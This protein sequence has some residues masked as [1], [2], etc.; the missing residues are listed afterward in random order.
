MTYKRDI[1]IEKG[2]YFEMIVEVFDQD[3]NPIDYTGFDS[4]AQFRKNIESN[5]AVTFDTSIDINNIT[6]SLSANSSI[7]VEPGKYMY[8]VLVR[9]ISDP[10]VV[11]K[12]IE[13]VCTV[14]PT[15]SQWPI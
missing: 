3:D 8:D 15:A 6:V 14:N 9:D 1:V 4:I 7:D 5:N 2:S 13:G 11:D 10:S 12:V